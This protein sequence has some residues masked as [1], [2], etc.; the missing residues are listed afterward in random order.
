M[1]QKNKRTL[2]LTS[3]ICIV[4]SIVTFILSQMGG[5]SAENYILLYVIAVSY[6]HLDVYKRQVL[7]HVNQLHIASSFARWVCD[8]PGEICCFLRFAPPAKTFSKKFPK[9]GVYRVAGGLSFVSLAE[10]ERTTEIPHRKG[11]KRWKRSPAMILIRGTAMTLSARRYSAT[12]PKTTCR[13]WRG[14]ATAKSRW[15]P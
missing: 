8:L 10:R 15:K 6:T 5:A 4:L 11:V 2:F 1:N 14:T 3:A 9:S 12:R 13:R 7:Y